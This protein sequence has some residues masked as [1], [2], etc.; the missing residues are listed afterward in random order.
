[1][2]NQIVPL[3]QRGVRAETTTGNMS[4][5]P[6]QTYYW[7]YLPYRLRDAFYTIRER[8][9]QTIYSYGTPIAI[10]V[11]GVWIIP[12]VTYSVTTSGKHQTHLYQ[13]GGLSVPWDCSLEELERVIAGKMRYVRDYNKKP[14]KWVPGTNWEPGC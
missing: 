12:D 14:G 11:D 1:M 3:A 8:I 10:M 13:L 5:E 9:T 2:N 4:T 7:G 6:G